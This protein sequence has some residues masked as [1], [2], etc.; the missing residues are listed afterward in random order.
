MDDNFNDYF[1]DENVPDEEPDVHQETE[2]EREEREIK[3]ATIE[4][5][6]ASIKM[7]LALV[8]IAMAL[9]LGWWVWQYYF[10]PYRISQE[11]GWIMKVKDEGTIFKTFEGDMISEGYVDDTIGVMKCDVDFSI[12]T[13]SLVRIATALAADGQRI[14]LS[15]KEYK[16]TVIWRGNSKRVATKIELDPNFIKP[17]PYRPAEVAEEPKQ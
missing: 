3:E 9:F 5:R 7:L 14:V 1:T 11:K 13:D 6:G 17:N 4:R 8:I 12:T 2:Q 15:Y 16:G 10:H